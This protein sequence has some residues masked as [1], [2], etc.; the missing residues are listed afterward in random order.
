[1]VLLR[2]IYMI[3]GCI[4]VLPLLPIILIVSFTLYKKNGIETKTIIDILG[5]QLFK[6]VKSNIDFVINGL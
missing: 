1:M 5:Q 3:L 6:S 2:C 4:V